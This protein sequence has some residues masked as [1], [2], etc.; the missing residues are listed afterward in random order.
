MDELLCDSLFPPNFVFF[1]FFFY[2]TEQKIGIYFV[3]HS[4]AC[5]RGVEVI[6]TLEC[7]K[8]MVMTRKH[9]P[10]STGHTVMAPGQAKWKMYKH[11]L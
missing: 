10:I 2:L 4:Q 5:L 11:M 7:Y 3:K 1:Y 9:P 8:D 6:H